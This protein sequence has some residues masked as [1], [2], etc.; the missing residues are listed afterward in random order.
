MSSVKKKGAKKLS[1]L[2]IRFIGCESSS[3]AFVC[4]FHFSEPRCIFLGPR[5]RS[6]IILPPMI[7]I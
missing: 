2:S 3:G 1:T 7:V 4:M 5:T 6:Q